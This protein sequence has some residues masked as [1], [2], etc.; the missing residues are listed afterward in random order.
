M[1]KARKVIAIDFGG[2]NIEAAVVTEDGSVLRPRFRR[3]TGHTRPGSEIA[4]DI[5]GLVS[6]LRRAHPDTVAAAV[7][8]PGIIDVVTGDYVFDPCNCPNWR[9]DGPVNLKKRVE[10]VAGVPCFVNNDAQVFAA[11]EERWGAA[12]RSGRRTGTRTSASSRCWL[13]L[14][15]GTGIG[16]ALRVNGRDFWGANNVIEIGHTC[17]DFTDSACLCG[18]GLRGCAEAYCSNTAIAGEA[19]RH[20]RCG[21]LPPPV[22]KGSAG[23]RRPS[24][25]WDAIQDEVD[26]RYVYD[27]AR[28]GQPVARAILDR[29]HAALATLIANFGNGLSIDLC[30]IGGGLTKAG[31]Y[32]FADVQQKVNARLLPIAKVEVVPAALGDD[33]ALLGAGAFALDMIDAR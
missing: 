9:R 2:V 16:G 32:L 12:R 33:F 4:D 29:A 25:A 21:K 7:G 15:L 13:F 26:A 28:A 14:T 3:P 1:S 31:D 10:A 22:Q 19:L 23:R 18:C 5:A 30:V 6:K 24:S 11:G 17:V 20:I 8:S 27:L